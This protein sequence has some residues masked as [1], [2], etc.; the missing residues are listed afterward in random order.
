MR[1]TKP[2][3]GTL[4]LALGN[5]IMGDV[6]FGLAVLARLRAMVSET[7]MLRLVDGGTWGMNLL[8]GIEDCD[9]LLIVDA[10]TC[11]QPGG[12]LV[13]LEK[14]QLP[15]YF[16]IHL[17]PHQVD[18]REVLAL[19]ELRETFPREAVAIGAEPVRI[20]MG[21]ELSGPVAAQVETVAGLVVRQLEHWG[22]RCASPV[23]AHA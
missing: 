19:A 10:I 9:R 14:D 13:R 21:T 6:G 18:L 22:H 11:G 2:P 17:S 8:P 4:V 7:A 12:S 1:T 5:P 15:R 23:M 3:A 20:E 16:S